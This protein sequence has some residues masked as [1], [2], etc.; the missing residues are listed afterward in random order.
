M[1]DWCESFFDTNTENQGALL[2]SCCI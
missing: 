1:G 2:I